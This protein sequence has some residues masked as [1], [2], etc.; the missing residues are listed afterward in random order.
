MARIILKC[1]YLKGGEKTA[2]HLSNLVKYI[3]TRDGVEKMESGHKLWHSTKKQ[4]DLIAQILREFP[5]AKELFEYEDYLENSNRGN[6]S[7]FITIALE[8]HLDKISGREKYLDYIA[9]RPRVEKFDSHGLFTAGDDPLV[10]SQVADEV[11]NHTGNVW[12]PIIS[13]RREDAAQMGYD[14]V[15]AWKALLSEKAV[16]I[17]ENM[18][19]HPDHLKWYA[20]FHNE[21]HHPHIHMVCYSTDPR[22][23][24]LTKQGIKKMKSSLANEIFRQ[25][26]IPLY[27]EK[28]Q[29]R[30]DLKEQAAESMREMIRQMKGGVLQSGRM[31]QLI[32]H[33]AERLQNTS[34][35]KQYGYL[36]AD[37]KNVVDEIVDEL[38]KDSR[39]AEAYRL[40]WEV[41]GRIESIY[42]ETPSEPP[43]LSRCDDFKPI[44]N[45]VIQEAL[46]IGSMTFEEPASVETALPESEDDLEMPSSDMAD[47]EDQEPADDSG[48]RSSS[49]EASA[50]K[51]SSDSWWTD[52]YKQ[53]KQ[54]LYGDEDAG[55]LQDF[56]KAHELFLME[57]E[58]DNPLALCDLGRMSADGLGCEADADEAYRWYEKALAVFHAA[59]EEKPWKYTEYRIGKM[60]AAGLGTEQD[61]LQAADWL[62]LS[63]DENYKYAQYSL[64]G[65]YY[66]GKGVD[67]DHESAFALYTRS[68]DQSFPYASFELGKML[69]DGIGCV[70]NQQDS[71]RRFKEAFLGFVSLE[72]QGHDDK[73]QYRLGWMLLNGVGTDKD[74]ARA[75]EYFEKAAFVGNPFAYH[76]LAKLI[77]SDEKAPQQDVEKALGYLKKAV[78]AENPYAA[79]FLGKLYEK[80]QH[81]PQNIAE[82]I[83]LYT[84]SAGQDNDFA[85]YRL[86]KLYLGGEGVLKDVESAIRWMTFAADRK[87][88]FAEYALGVLYFKGEDVPKDV[89]KALEYLKRSAGQG[90]QFAQYRLGKIYLMGEDVPKDIQTALQFLT[91]AAEQGNQYAQYTLGKLYLMGKD[92]PKDKETAVRWFTLSAAQGNIYAR[93][94]LGHIDDFKDPSVLLAGTR[95]LHHMSRVFA[96]NAPPLKPPGQR[97]DRKLLRKLRE[98]KQ[99]QGHARD[100]HEQTMS[101]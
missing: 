87:N 62:T 32:T 6:A 22:E 50:D 83:R 100:D 29:R 4:K 94:F 1:P 48:E 72:E 41:R 12:T 14:N 44:R 7:E 39:I 53:A 25:E 2:A 77:L 3:A 30:D 38:A 59:E 15:L 55:I 33:L 52:G 82:A 84:L 51:E 26:L 35:K 56:E 73:L 95:L 8:R 27:G 18:K 60:Y 49:D 58:A 101:L 57:A 64:G 63:A 86:G 93:F 31:E 16:E 85:A 91:A 97:T 66:H 78:E 68:A 65:L 21:S 28:T 74:E 45:M 11:A 88:Q 37:L 69:R 5:D 71:D 43:P 61:Y 98:K 76:Q 34:G 54:Y 17:A 81:V 96:D 67:Q 23:G 75:K 70:K 79:Y 24:Y 89:P 10:L 46:L 90:N 80:G 42:T 9:N 40:W 19:I 99:A 47:E 20:A 92:V 36:K 13:L